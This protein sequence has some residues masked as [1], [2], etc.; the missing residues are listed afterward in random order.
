MT[1]KC[2]KNI[3]QQLLLMLNYMLQ[4]YIYPAYISKHNS[5][6]EKKIMCFMIIKRKKSVVHDNKKCETVWN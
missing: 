3:I 5:G 6:H 2:L 4:K 1:G